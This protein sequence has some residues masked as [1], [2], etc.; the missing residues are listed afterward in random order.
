MSLDLHALGYQRRG[1]L[2]ELPLFLA[3]GLFANERCNPFAH[4]WAQKIN[5]RVI[6]VFDG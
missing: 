1:K 3:M 4:S 6:A 5:C 2:A